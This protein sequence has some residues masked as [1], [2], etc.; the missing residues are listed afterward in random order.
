[1]CFYFSIF[2]WERGVGWGEILLKDVSSLKKIT[3]RI[4]LCFFLFFLF[5]LLLSVI[6]EDQN[7]DVP[8]KKTAEVAW[9]I[10]TFAQ[11][12]KSLK[13]G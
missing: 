8:G 4:V 13:N 2:F 5:L 9:V 3:M 11:G 6:V 7:L 12:A 10:Q 1:M